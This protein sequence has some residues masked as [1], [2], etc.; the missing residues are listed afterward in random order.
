[1][2]NPEELSKCTAPSN[3]PA[4]EIGD[5]TH[6]NLSI[7]S[8]GVSLLSVGLS[9]LFLL[10]RFTIAAIVLDV[11]FLS[12]F[13]VAVV[14]DVGFCRCQF[15]Y[16]SKKSRPATRR[17]SWTLVSILVAFVVIWVPMALFKPTQIICLFL[18]AC[19]AIFAGCK[20]VAFAARP[21]SLF[22]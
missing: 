15:D 5:C 21:G 1:M 7:F 14:T 18:I 8:I 4:K 2:S 19:A 9:F 16:A 13:V 22:R 17:E 20:M 12:G 10:L 3:S 6:R 11:L